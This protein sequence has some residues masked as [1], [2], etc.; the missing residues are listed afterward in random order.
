MY[1]IHGFLS[2]PRVYRLQPPA[3]HQLNG[4]RH[5]CARGLSGVCGGGG[6]GGAGGKGLFAVGGV[7]FWLGVGGGKFFRD[8]YYFHMGPKEEK[9]PKIGQANNFK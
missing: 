5:T 8:P 3:N 7:G 9:G 6:G 4:A 2:S 1:S